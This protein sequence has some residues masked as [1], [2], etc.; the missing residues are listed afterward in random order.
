MLA[1][2][3]SEPAQNTGDIQAYNASRFSHHT[4]EEILHLHYNHTPTNSL[5]KMKGKVRGLP[6]VIHNSC[7]TFYSNIGAL[8]RGA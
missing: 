1:E 6:H 5:S 3:H 4:L 8:C 7:M 2:I